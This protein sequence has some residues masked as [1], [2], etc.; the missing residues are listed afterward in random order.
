MVEDD[1]ALRMVCRVALELER[2]RVRE[3]EGIDAARAA[4]ADER[5]G[6]V[7]L[8][9]HLAGHPSDTLLEE[10]MD[11]GVPVVVVTGTAEINEYAGRATEVIEKPFDPADLAA[12]AH[13]HMRER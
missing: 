3:A 2:F 9:V 5:P 8:D 6:L 1:P 10:L 11:D 7:F 12:A 13:R 4:V